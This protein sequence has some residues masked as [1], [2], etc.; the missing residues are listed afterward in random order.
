MKN[1]LKNWDVS[2][3]LRL[4][5]GLGIGVYALITTEYLLLILAGWLLMQGVLNISCCGTTCASQGT[6]TDK[7]DLYKDQIKKYK[8]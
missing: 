2:R 5:L 1:L 8:P 6:K 3:I 4:V 7:R